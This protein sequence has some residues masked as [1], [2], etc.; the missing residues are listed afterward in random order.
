M[1]S[2]T[3]QA[4]VR[5]V[6]LF[7]LKLFLSVIDEGQIGRA[8]AREHIAPSAATKRIQDLESLAGLKLFDRSARGI[9]L[10]DAGRVFERHIRTVL[11]T[12]DELRGELAAFAEG[13][14]GHVSI[15]SLRMLIVQF[16]AKE[17]AEFTQRFPLVEV[18][19]REDTNPSVIR[20]L[21]SGEVDLA[22]YSHSAESD[23]DEGLESHEWRTDRLIAVVP[24]GHS[25]ARM[26]S[27]SLELL[28]DQD[29]IG[30]G[31][32]T[33]VMTNLRYAA[34]Q[35]GREPR[36]RYSV[37]TVEAARSLVSAGFGVA[38]QPAS[39]LF[40]D[41]RE[42]VALI[43]IEGEWAARSYRIGKLKGK[44]LSPAAAAL[45]EQLISLPASGA[46]STSPEILDAVAESSHSPLP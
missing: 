27:L 7:S 28:L 24:V 14:C 43:D 13:T 25:L 11:A 22:L 15:A 23:Y 32:T 21:L 10:T 36:V 12:L 37:S 35:I 1:K 29:L 42:R 17:I 26:S 16:L 40:L 18:E 3:V 44:A 38:L 33:T 8:A 2:L 45:L 5:Q 46:S 41:E 39:M 19:L 6:D 31:D 30:I 34:R 4:L 20:A 9:V